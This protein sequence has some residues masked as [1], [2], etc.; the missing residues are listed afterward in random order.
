[1]NKNKDFERR[2]AFTMHEYNDLKSCKN[3]HAVIG[4]SLHVLLLL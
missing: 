1:M 2:G 4:K 3:K